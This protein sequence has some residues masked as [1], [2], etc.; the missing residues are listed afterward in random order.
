MTIVN[1]KKTVASLCT[2]CRTSKCPQRPN[3]D[4]DYL[5]S[6]LTLLVQGVWDTSTGIGNRGFVEFYIPFKSNV[7]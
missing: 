2:S 6:L 5:N 7:T 4:V 1:K 3:S